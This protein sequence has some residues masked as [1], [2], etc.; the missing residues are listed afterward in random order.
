MTYVVR[1][2]RVHKGI[3]TTAYG[4]IVSMIKVGSQW[5]FHQHIESQTGLNFHTWTMETTFDLRYGSGSQTP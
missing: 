1:S 4:T 3:D 5:E 2:C